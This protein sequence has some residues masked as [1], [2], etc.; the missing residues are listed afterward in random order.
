MAQLPAPRNRPGEG[1]RRRRSRRTGRFEFRTILPGE[2][3][4]DG[5][6]ANLSDGVLS[7]MIPKAEQAKPRRIQVTG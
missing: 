2:V 5:V 3:N 1:E 4:Q 6:S 7:V